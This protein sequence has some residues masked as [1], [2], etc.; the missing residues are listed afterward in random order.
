MEYLVDEYPEVGLALR[1]GVRKAVDQSGPL[2]AVERELVM[3]GA[4]TAARQ[5]RAFK[6]HCSRA[7]AAGA[8][9]ERVRHAV[10]LTLGAS[11]TL[12]MVVDALR[13]TDEVIGGEGD[14]D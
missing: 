6:L 5:P 14:D 4:Y 12:E 9:P 10:L 8:E 1:D 11:A 7:L 3:L 13:W 2:S